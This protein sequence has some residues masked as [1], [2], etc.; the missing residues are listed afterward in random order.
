MT[1]SNE[2]RD[3]E[4]LL[5]MIQSAEEVLMFTEDVSHEAFLQNRLLQLGTA[6]LIEQIAESARAMQK[7]FR[8]R[9]DAY[10]WGEMIGMRTVLVHEYWKID[11]DKVYEAAQNEVPELLD[12]LHEIKA[13]MQKRGYS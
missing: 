10:P 9:Y 5:R 12:Y 1:I 4:R 6:K 2:Q 3:Y 13:E 7:A 8:D 11:P